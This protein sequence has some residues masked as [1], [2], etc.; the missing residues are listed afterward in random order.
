MKSPR[1]DVV[2]RRFKRGESLERIASGY[3]RSAG[4]NADPKAVR[5][6]V[7]DALRRHMVAGKPVR[8]RRKR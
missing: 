4:P 5:L 1:A 6:A 2:A 8:I 3:Y 7:E